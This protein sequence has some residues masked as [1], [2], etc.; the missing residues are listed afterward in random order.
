MRGTG[1]RSVRYSDQ[2]YEDRSIESARRG[3]DRRGSLSRR[4]GLENPPG[5]MHGD[6]AAVRKQQDR[7]IL[8]GEDSSGAQMPLLDSMSHKSNSTSMGTGA[9]TVKEQVGVAIRRMEGD[10]LEQGEAT[11]EEQLKIDNLIGRGAFGTVY[12]GAN[13]LS[14][15]PVH[16]PIW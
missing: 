14:L 10:L 15:H 1:A 9:A 2:A 8:L 12:R 7:S 16:R 3:S 11:L 6:P 4:A 5:G 13:P